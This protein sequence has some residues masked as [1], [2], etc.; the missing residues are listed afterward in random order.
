MV[1]GINVCFGKYQGLGNMDVLLNCNIIFVRINV[2][3]GEQTFVELGE[4]L[5]SS[6]AQ[7]GKL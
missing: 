5:S 7:C 4:I 2:D 3:N 1:L 6:L